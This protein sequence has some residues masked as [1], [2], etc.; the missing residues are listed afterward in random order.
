MLEAIKSESMK[1]TKFKFENLKL[2]N[3]VLDFVYLVCKM[4]NTFLKTE[5]TTKNQPL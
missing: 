5:L 3:K 2:Y 4:N 1:K